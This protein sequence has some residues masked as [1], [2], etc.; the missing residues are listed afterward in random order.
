MTDNNLNVEDNGNPLRQDGFHV[1]LDARALNISAMGTGG[2]ET[3]TLSTSP[4]SDN[5][6]NTRLYR[7]AALPE[8]TQVVSKKD[9]PRLQCRNGDS[10]QLSKRKADY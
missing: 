10:P 6:A 5:S 4:N 2:R 1:T 7:R 8:G 3:L 9:R